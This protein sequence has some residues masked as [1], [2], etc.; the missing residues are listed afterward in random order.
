M[1]SL[2]TFILFALW[3]L[4]PGK[5]LI[6]LCL[7]SIWN[8][9]TYLISCQWLPQNNHNLGQNEYLW[10]YVL[11]FTTDYIFL[12]QNLSSYT[13][14]LEIYDRSPKD[15]ALLLCFYSSFMPNLSYSVVLLLHFCSLMNKILAFSYRFRLVEAISGSLSLVW[16]LVIVTMCTF[17]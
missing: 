14:I 1:Q 11:C 8:S 2:Q 4:W 17:V 13:L 6:F 5:V 15:L 9:H 10:K 12:L 7:L 3:F 16:C